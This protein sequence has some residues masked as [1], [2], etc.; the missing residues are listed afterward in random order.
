M[1][2]AALANN[3]NKMFLDF[4]LFQTMNMFIYGLNSS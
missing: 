4:I 2:N 1:R 3:G